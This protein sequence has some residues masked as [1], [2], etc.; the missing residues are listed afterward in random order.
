MIKR[1]DMDVGAA[2][3]EWTKYKRIVPVRGAILLNDTLDQVVVVRA[4]KGGS[5]SFPR[6]KINR[7]ETDENCA[8]REVYEETG[9]KMADMVKSEDVIE[10]N[11]PGTQNIKLYIVPGVSMDTV[12]ETKTR[13]EISVGRTQLDIGEMKLIFG[14]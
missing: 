14:G 13:G 8:I 6:G 10:G 1:W 4:M 5:L 11:S 3:D 9:F 2:Y 12:F 7:E